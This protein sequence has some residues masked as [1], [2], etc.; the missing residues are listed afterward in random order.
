MTLTSRQAPNL[1]AVPTGSASDQ[2]DVELRRATAIAKATEA[3]PRAYR[4]QPGAILLADAW[5]RERGLD[6]LTAIQSVAFIDG[7]PV[8]DATLQRALAER[9]G[10]TVAVVDVTAEAA[11]VVI[12]RGA[13]E[14]G[15]VTYT[16]DDAK[17]ANL[18]GKQNWRTNPKAMLVAA[19]TRTA[20]RW[21]APSVLVGVFDADELVDPADVLTAVPS[22]PTAAAEPD[23]APDAPE[24]DPAPEEPAQ[25]PDDIIDAELVPDATPADELPLDEP[26]TDEPVETM[27]KDELRA[28]LKAANVR[29]SDAIRH[30]QNVAGPDVEVHNLDGIIA[31][32]LIPS[33]LAW[34]DAG[35]P[36]E[37]DA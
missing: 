16:L 29:Q 9:A 19:A 24:P 8:V 12:R 1:P 25:E 6:T 28:T 34:L 15:R 21:H 30:A 31:A 36:T 3:L 20:I 35:A 17:A 13:T 22:E 33:L 26:A 37:A 7:R 18:A 2:L 10:Y 4:N 5:A 11:T 27:G 23:P 32:G 14:L